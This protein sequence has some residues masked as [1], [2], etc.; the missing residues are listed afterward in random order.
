MMRGCGAAAGKERGK[1][2]RGGWSALSWSGRRGGEV[3]AGAEVAGD[4]E[5]G[6][7]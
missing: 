4:R 2:R 6:E 7:S 3:R 1:G 5:E